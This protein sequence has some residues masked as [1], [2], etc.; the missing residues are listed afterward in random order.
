MLKTRGFAESVQ[1]DQEFLGVLSIKGGES[2]ST[3]FHTV[4]RRTGRSAKNIQID[5]TNYYLSKQGPPGTIIRLPRYVRRS[6]DDFITC[7]SGAS[8]RPRYRH[9]GSNKDQLP[10]YGRGQPKS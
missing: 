7:Q 10:I 8:P 9:A 2:E 4:G 3:F 1:A 6:V 5:V